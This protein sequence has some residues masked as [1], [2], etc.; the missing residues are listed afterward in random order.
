MQR[1]FQKYARFDGRASR[2]EYWWWVLAN[3]LIVI[4]LEI[5]LFGLASAS[6]TLG[7]LVGIV[8]FA[9]ALGVL[10]PS[11]AVGVRRLHDAGYSG[12]LLLL[13]LIPFVG[14]IIVI[15]LMCMPSKPE[16]MQYDQRR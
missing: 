12:L 16:G 8:L 14:G 9:Y 1:I 5:V 10:V 3:F 2:G 15:V 6:S 7:V 4:V 11:I 13:G